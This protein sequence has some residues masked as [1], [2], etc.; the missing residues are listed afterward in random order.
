MRSIEVGPKELGWHA[1][2]F[3]GRTAPFELIPLMPQDSRPSH[4][5]R[6]HGQ[7]RCVVLAEDDAEMRRLVADALRKVGHRVIEAS[8]GTELLR[9][10]ARLTTE[11]SRDDAKVDL[12]VTDVRM[13]GGNGLDIVEILRSARSET[14]VIVMTAFGDSETRARANR[15]GAI[16]LDKPFRIDLLMKVVRSL[17]L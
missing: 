17:L 15:V 10:T 5:E 13:P 1:I 12:I 4:F 14:P 8:D 9:L 3:V 7:Q 11:D 2:C 6:S 16:L